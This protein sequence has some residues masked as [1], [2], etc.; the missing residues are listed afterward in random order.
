S[1]GRSPAVYAALRRALEDAIPDAGRIPSA[2]ELKNTLYLAAVVK[3]LPRYISTEDRTLITG[4]AASLAPGQSLAERVVPG[5]TVRQGI[6]LPAGT[7]I[8]AQAWF[9]E[10][11]DTTF[12]DSNIFQPDR[13]LEEIDGMQTLYADA[14]MTATY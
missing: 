10:R 2:Q 9:A 6:Y 3:V 1:L 8:A 11:C 14:N 12:A 7:I 5:G 13:W 4:R